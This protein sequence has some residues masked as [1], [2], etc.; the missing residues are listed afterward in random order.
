MYISTCMWQLD[1]PMGACWQ[2]KGACR[3]MHMP[4]PSRRVG[5]AVNRGTC[6]K[7][8]VRA[9]DRVQRTRSATTNKQSR[10]G[11]T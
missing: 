9:M 6:L 5:P 1:L 3:A 8:E 10:Y 2:R 7:S 4:R 11:L